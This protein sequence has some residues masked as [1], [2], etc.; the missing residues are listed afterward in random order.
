MKFSWGKFKAKEKNMWKSL[1][2]DTSKT[3]GKRNKL[4]QK[5]GQTNSGGFFTDSHTLKQTLNK[6]KNVKMKYS[7]HLHSKYQN[8]Q[9][10]RSYLD[11]NVSK[12]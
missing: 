3:A 2:T 7:K 9:T 5:E 4:L 12:D 1:E 6:I 11:Q 10:V 8:G